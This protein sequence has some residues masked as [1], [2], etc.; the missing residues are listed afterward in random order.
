MIYNTAKYKGTQ[1]IH[2]EAK[3][4]WQGKL[5]TT[6]VEVIGTRTQINNENT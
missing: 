6:L 1:Q 4:W 2:T 3:G 5:T